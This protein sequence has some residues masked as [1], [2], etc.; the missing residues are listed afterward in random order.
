LNFIFENRWEAV[1]EGK[2]ITPVSPSGPFALTDTAFSL[3]HILIPGSLQDQT[4]PSVATE[5]G[6]LLPGGQWRQRRRCE[7]RRY[8]VAALGL[9]HHSLQCSRTVDPPAHGRSVYQHHHRRPVQM[10]CAPG[11]RGLL[12]TRD[13]SIDHNFRLGG[14][15]LASTRQSFVRRGISACAH[16]RASD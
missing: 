13:Q 11:C 12:R 10:D 4:G 2:G 15:D 14:L 7:F 3:K 8:C 9:G 6:V 1:L 16:R 5:F